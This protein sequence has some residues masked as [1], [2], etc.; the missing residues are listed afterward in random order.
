MNSVE[1][2]KFMLPDFLV[3]NFEIVSAVNSEENLRLYFVEK[4]KT[5]KR[6]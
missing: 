4:S 1:L 6:V 3:H 2:L 5:T